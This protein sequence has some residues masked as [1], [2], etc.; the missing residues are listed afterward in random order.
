MGCSTIYINFNTVLKKVYL[1]TVR[2]SRIAISATYQ[3]NSLP[4]M[5]VFSPT[6]SF[7]NESDISKGNRIY[8]SQD[9]QR[10]KR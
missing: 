5:L 4:P 2:R 9:Q 3:Y 1:K 10:N 6:W 8:W 7:K